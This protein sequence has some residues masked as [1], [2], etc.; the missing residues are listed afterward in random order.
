MYSF[1]FGFQRFNISWK[2]KQ[3]KKRVTLY[4]SYIRFIL[5]HVFI[6]Y[7]LFD[8]G[9]IN[10]RTSEERCLVAQLMPNRTVSI[11]RKKWHEHV[12]KPKKTILQHSHAQYNVNC[13]SIE[14][15]TKECHNASLVTTVYK[16]CLLL[17]YIHL[18]AKAVPLHAKKSLGVRG[19]I[20]STHSR[21][22]N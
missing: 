8:S 13:Y 15:W 4:D 19:G 5:R 20:A 16:L 18:K 21:P 10:R 12:H 3:W 22:R 6:I 14:I 7:L 9:S 11:R 1:R 17:N 2:L